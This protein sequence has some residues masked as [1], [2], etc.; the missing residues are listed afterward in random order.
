MDLALSLKI[1]AKYSA[2]AFAASPKFKCFCR[3]AEF[4]AEQTLPGVLAVSPVT[5]FQYNCL[6]TVGSGVLAKNLM[7][8]L[9]QKSNKISKYWNLR[10]RFT[11]HTSSDKVYY[12]NTHFQVQLL[13]RYIHTHSSS[14]SNCISLC[15]RCTSK[16]QNKLADNVLKLFF[17]IDYKCR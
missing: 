6:E 14:I 12:S 9:P 5:Q 17:H 7:F 2:T 4:Q 15:N 1:S 16:Q 11:L 8:Q 13:S 10:Q 3:V